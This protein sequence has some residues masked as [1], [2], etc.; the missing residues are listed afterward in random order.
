MRKYLIPLAL[1]ATPAHA[2]TATEVRAV[3]DDAQASV[4]AALVNRYKRDL[5]A[6]YALNR[7]IADELA[8]ALLRRDPALLAFLA[9]Y[10]PGAQTC[11][12][13][14]AEAKSRADER[15]AIVEWIEGRK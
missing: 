11:D 7:F 5:F 10:M 13:A 15:A 6:G 2:Q 1:I 12:L 8:H 14:G 9:R 3:S 4:E